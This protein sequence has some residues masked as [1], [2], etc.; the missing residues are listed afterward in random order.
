MKKRFFAFICFL[1]LAATMVQAE[2]SVGS[3]R[4][5]SHLNQKPLSDISKFPPRAVV[6]LGE[7]NRLIQLHP[8]KKYQKEVDRA[9][10]PSRRVKFLQASEETSFTIPGFEA[11]GCGEC[12]KAEQLLDRSI[13]RMQKS[14]DRL[15]SIHRDLPLPPLKQFIIQPWA[16]EW[17]RP[18]QFAH[19]TFDTIRIF[20]SA[21]LIDSRVYGNATHLHESLHLT[22]T[23]LGVANELEA[24]SLNIRSDP[25]FLL[26]NFPYFSDTVTAFFIPEFA[27]I[28]DRFFSREVIEGSTVLGED[29]IVP[30]EVQ[31]FLMP[32]ED[33]T[34]SRVNVAIEKLEPVLQE[35]SRLNRKYPLESAYLGEQ[36]RAVSLLL[37]IAA[38]KTLPL[39]PLNLD[40]ST[41]KEALAILDI[42][43]NKLDNTR[44]GYRIDR[45]REALMT[46][47]YHLRLKDSA[48][49]L[50]IYF[51][52]LKQRFIGADGEIKLVVPD[53]EDF[54]KFIEEKRR[55]IAKMAGSP[56]LTPI[57][58]EGALRMLKSIPD[59]T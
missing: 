10:G 57:E 28:L 24:Y 35:V 42:Q 38:V 41:M 53:E 11:Y 3:K 32:F 37:D 55:E 56:K 27:G 49:R 14:L 47:T 20:P 12:H 21:I 25:R 5:T 13:G 26:L 1:V 46:L 58:K 22:Q 4:D 44:L 30:R 15:S 40:S 18:G 7:L 23:F 50:G 31:W 33:D 39:P 17:L 9:K 45:K 8:P 54:K 34:L 36:T 43:F 51:R 48:T 29:M 19:T 16:D 2:E 6:G 59:E 52:F